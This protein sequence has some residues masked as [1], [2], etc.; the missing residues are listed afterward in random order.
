MPQEDRDGQNL[1]TPTVRRTKSNDNTSTARSPPESELEHEKPPQTNEDTQKGPEWSFR[2]VGHTAKNSEDRPVRCLCSQV[3]RLIV[4]VMTQNAAQ[5]QAGK[6]STD[7]V[8]QAPSSLSRKHSGVSINT[9][10][11]VQN[12]LDGNLRCGVTLERIGPLVP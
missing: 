1:K 10:Q 11:V 2:I 8:Q 7:V 5:R 6:L 3:L 4:S 9:S 12:S